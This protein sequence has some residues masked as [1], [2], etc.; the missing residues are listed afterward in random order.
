[1]T[2]YRK[3]DQRTWTITVHT[4]DPARPYRR[5]TSGTRDKAT[6]VAM[7][8]ML[9]TVGR[10]GKRWLWILD[11]ILADRVTI[12]EVYD[13]YVSGT[14]D[15]LQASLE[16]LD[17][18]PLVA[19]WEA[20]LLQAVAD[21]GL[22][23]ETVRKYRHQVHVLAGV[24]GLW[25][26]RITGPALRQ[27][28]DALPGSN[29]NRRRH[30]AAWTSFLDFAVER[31][32]LPAN[33]L[34]A[35]K[36]PKSNR[37]RERWLPWPVVLRLLHAMPAGPHRAMAALRH[38][39]F[40]M[41]AVTATHR[42]DVVDLGNRIVW[43]HGSK[44]ATRDRQVIILDDAC[45]AIFADYVQAGRF[46]PDAPLFP[47][48]AA[49]HGRVHRETVAALAAEGVAIPAWYT[50]HA[51]RHSFAVEMVKRGYE[52]KLIASILGHANERLAQQLYA[53]HQPKAEDLIRSAR[54]AERRA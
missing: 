28:L 33:P 19:A 26:S 53:K 29:T 25:R 40:E 24:D 17:L 23:A 54:R 15:A 8:Q 30:A 44:T 16:D 52:L 18:L 6:A 34:R 5:L 39:G 9:E 32:A 20:Q 22:A 12:P 3:Q 41:Q 45:W 2:P 4:G 49:E 48:S 11:G 35:L 46:L 43:A 42:R 10:R 38:S 51:A 27:R 47:V 37:A 50:L 36:L 7:E 14:L 21:G 31:G 13:H 1:M